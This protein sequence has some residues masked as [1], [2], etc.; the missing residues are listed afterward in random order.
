MSHP[1]AP[2]PGGE[3]EINGKGGGRRAPDRRCLRPDAGVRPM[4]LSFGEIQTFVTDLGRAKEFYR[5]VLGLQ[6]CAESP[7]WLVFDVSG[8]AFVVLPGGSP[9]ARDR[10]YGSDCATVLCLRTSSVERERARLEGHGIRFLTPTKTVPQGR[11]AAF[12]DPDGNLLELIEKTEA[13]EDESGRR[14]AWR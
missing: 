12:Q 2:D 9:V 10:P 8:V 5:D 14:P 4:R 6:L 1:G 3:Q 7:G 11:F 13:D